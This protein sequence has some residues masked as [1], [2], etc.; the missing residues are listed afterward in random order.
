MGLQGDKHGVPAGMSVGLPGCGGTSV[1][2]QGDE[3]GASGLRG[4][5]KAQGPGGDTEDDPGCPANWRT[6]A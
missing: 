2:L 3:R 5:K 4:R 1:G 6:P